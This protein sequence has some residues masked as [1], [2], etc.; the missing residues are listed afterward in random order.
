MGGVVSS[1]SPIHSIMNNGRLAFLAA[2]I[3]LI[4]ATAHA[5]TTITW[6]RQQL[7]G[8]FYSEG[9]AIGDINGDGKP[10]RKSVV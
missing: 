5:E 10:D 9:A 7:H 8:D 3:S 6:K 1:P 2:A 4:S